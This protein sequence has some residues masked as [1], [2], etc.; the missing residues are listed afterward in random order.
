MWAILALSAAALTSFN[1]I[2]YKRMLKDAEA[3]VVVWAVTLLSLP[4]LGLF[5]L[6]L[7]RQLPSLD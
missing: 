4:L 1:P 6:G 7:T 2:L 5:T 3:V